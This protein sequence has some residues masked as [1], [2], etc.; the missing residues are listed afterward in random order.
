V[1]IRV[2]V[3]LRFQWVVIEEIGEAP[4]QPSGRFRIIA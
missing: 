2:E 1:L 3:V 4:L